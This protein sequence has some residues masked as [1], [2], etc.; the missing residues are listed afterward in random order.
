MVCLNINHMWNQ[1]RGI[2]KLNLCIAFIIFITAC[3]TL[4]NKECLNTERFRCYLIIEDYCKKNKSD[5]ENYK[6][7]S[8]ENKSLEDRNYYLYNVFPI[9]NDYTYRIDID[10]SLSYLPKDYIEYE[11]KIF[12]IE[13]RENDNVVSDE[14]LKYL[15]SLKLLDSTDVKI[16][17]GMLREEDRIYRRYLKKEFQEGVDYVICKDSPFKISKQ[18]KTNKYIEPDDERFSEV[19]N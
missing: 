7:F 11:D 4:E 16:Q 15:D 18:V 10:N 17:L 2:K 8:V 9:Y 1:R 19:C 13:D 6:F 5:V 3:K 14:L 12:F